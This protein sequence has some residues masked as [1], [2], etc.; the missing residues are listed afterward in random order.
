MKKL[1]PLFFVIL[2]FSCKKEDEK[3]E[4]KS[5]PLL[6]E[7]TGTY[8]EPVYY[9]I[10]FSEPHQSS[11]WYTTATGTTIAYNIDKGNFKGGTSVNVGVTGYKLDGSKATTSFSAKPFKLK[12]TYNSQIL[13]EKTFADCD[14]IAVYVDLPFIK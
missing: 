5:A 10:W 6:I 3:P 12:V 4:S 7:F 9:K 13:S 2:L 1:I 8:D 11:D 14:G